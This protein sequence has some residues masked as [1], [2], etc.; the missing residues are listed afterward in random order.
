MGGTDTLGMR[1]TT[2]SVRPPKRSASAH[3]SPGSGAARCLPDLLAA[4][5]AAFGHFGGRCEFLL[6]DRMRTVVLGTVTLLV[7]PPALVQE[8]QAAL[9]LLA[10]S[11]SNPLWKRLRMVWAVARGKI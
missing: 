6:Y 3:T 10:R 8:E 2:V 1:T 5:E 7:P 11:I 4:H 9:P